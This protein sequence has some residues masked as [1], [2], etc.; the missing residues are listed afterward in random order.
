MPR[1]DTIA[2]FKRFDKAQMLVLLQAISCHPSNQKYTHR[3]EHLIA[4]LLGIPEAGFASRVVQR[5]DLVFLFEKISAQYE[6]DFGSVEDFQGFSQL[7]LIPLFYG[8]RKYHIFYSCFERPVENWQQLVDIIETTKNSEKTLSSFKEAMMHSLQMQTD[9][10][11]CIL[12][13]DGIDQEYHHPYVPDECFLQSVAPYFNAYSDQIRMFFDPESIAHLKEEDLL[14]L[15]PNVGDLFQGLYVSIHGKLYWLMPQVHYSVL[16]QYLFNILDSD[17][18]TRTESWNGLYNR[19]QRQLLSTFHKSSRIVAITT[20]E[21]RHILRAPELLFLFDLNKIFFFQIIPHSHG[22]SLMHTL[23]KCNAA[24]EKIMHNIN[25]Q[26]AVVVFPSEQSVGMGIAPANLEF[27]VVYVMENLQNSYSYKRMLGGSNWSNWY[28][29]FADLAQ[30]LKMLETPLEFYKF[31]GEDE[32]LLEN[33]QMPLGS[34]FMDRFICFYRNG[35]TYSRMAELPEMVYFK[36]HQWSRY[37]FEKT[38]E[39]YK[40]NPKL[41]EAMGLQF[42]KYDDITHYRNNVYRLAN[43]SRY[44][45]MYLVQLPDRFITIYLADDPLALSFEEYRFGYEVLAAMFGD[46]LDRAG[47]VVSSALVRYGI[48]DLCIYIFPQNYISLK[49]LSFLEDSAKEIT[50]DNPFALTASFNGGKK[51]VYCLYDHKNIHPYFAAEDN[52]AERRL[53][54]ELLTQIF[55]TGDEESSGLIVSLIELSVPLGRKGYSMDEVE[56]ENIDIRHYQKPPQSTQTD[57]GKVRRLIAG[58]LKENNYEPRVY[59]GSQAMDLAYQL[60]LFL[61]SQL[62]EEI[63]NSDPEI[64]IY[65]YRQLEYNE[66]LAERQKLQLGMQADRVTDYKVA[67]K[68]KESVADAIATASTIRYIIH[69]CLQTRPDG[70]NYITES[71]WTYLMAMAEQIIQTAML[72][73]YIKYGLVNHTILINEYHEFQEV[74]TGGKFEMNSYLDQEAASK[75]SLVRNAF[76]NAKTDRKK[77]EV[78]EEF[79]EWEGEFSKVFSQQFGVSYDNIIVVLYVISKADYDTVQNFPVSFASKVQLTDIILSNMT[80]DLTREEIEKTIE[81]LTLKPGVFGPAQPLYHGVLLRKRQRLTLCPFVEI[82]E[83]EL[84][85]GREVLDGALNIWSEVVKGSLPFKVEENSEVYKFLNQVRIE[86]GAGFEKKIE[87]IAEDTLGRD[88]VEMRIDNFKRLS[89]HFN[90]REDC[91]E[92]D[93]LCVNAVSK[94]LF[95]MDCKNLLKKLG[96]YQISR[97]IE[98]FFIKRD[99]HYHQL[100]QKKEF[101]EEHLAE[102]LL[103]FG[104]NDVTGWTIKHGF[105]VSNVQFAAFYNNQSADFILAEELAAYLTA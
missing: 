52:S 79:E 60:Y 35:R 81:F 4:L 85:F 25:N 44:D 76:K 2:F 48:E 58:Y 54:R 100:V 68:L 95:V 73:D 23:E 87:R 45:Q 56:I 80:I 93:L 36:H 13:Q 30:V 77:N 34:E 57:R 12:K 94:T 91:G 6:N 101:V 86:K 33:C 75:V 5:S 26:E 19:C 17:N 27:H 41:F 9:L 28:F 49:E 64:I 11:K 1:F 38:F 3:F 53:Y 92:I 103:H 46:F 65:A 10:L 67:D 8:Q 82:K 14:E 66:G 51:T 40:A 21:Q 59:D 70:N 43:T 20:Q 69:A 32:W 18:D 89:D 42:C 74:I 15:T 96:L 7:A 104:V 16:V 72:Y 71:S 29:E 102:V 105:V 99:S 88:C 37:Y 62:K 83:G 98:S 50:R 39:R 31:L 22:K 63:K 90:T 47:T 55:S 24:T 78:S 97:E 84:M 61:H